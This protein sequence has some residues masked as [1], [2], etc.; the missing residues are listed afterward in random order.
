MKTSLPKIGACAEKRRAPH[1]RL[2]QSFQHAVVVHGQQ[3][4]DLQR[5]PDSAL[6]GRVW[7]GD[8]RQQLLVIADT[9]PV[10]VGVDALAVED[11]RTGFIAPAPAPPGVNTQGVVEHGPGV[12]AGQ[13]RNT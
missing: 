7:E 5:P 11:G 2:D 3:P 12:I 10:P 9:A 8:R 1:Q 4:V 6:H 13:A